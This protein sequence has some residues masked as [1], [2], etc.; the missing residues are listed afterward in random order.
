MAKLHS[1]KRSDVLLSKE[2]I[3]GWKREWEG[4]D[5]NIANAEARVQELR[6]RKIKLAQLLR[7]AMVFAPGLENWI[8]LQEASRPLGGPQD[9][10]DDVALTDAILSVL[11]HRFPLSVSREE[12]RLE[13][14]AHGYPTEKIQ[15]NPN[16]L[17]TALGRLV[18]SGKIVEAVPAGH[19]V[20]RGRSEEDT[21]LWRS[22][23][24]VK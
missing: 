23:V 17:Y 6:T 16:Y 3:E 7:G 19:Y 2:D 24:V 1:G 21:R 9:T 20:V 13:L 18:R 15:N 4:I 5:D 12:I 11:R 10:S 22:G 14:P 8:H